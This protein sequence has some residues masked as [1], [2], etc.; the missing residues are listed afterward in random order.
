M[1]KSILVLIALYLCVFSIKAQ[2]SPDERD[3]LKQLN[4][5]VVT[6]YKAGKIDDALI[7]AKQSVD[8]SVKVFGAE[9]D[10][11]AAA[12]SNLGTLYRLKK[13]YTEAAENLQKAL[14]IYNLRP[15]KNGKSLAKTLDNLAAVYALDGDRK[16]AAETYQTALIAAENAFGKES[17]ELLPYLKSMTDV[18]VFNKKL[19]EAQEVLARRYKIAEKSLPDDTTQLTE[20]S[21][22]FTCFVH[23]NFSREEV[24]GRQKQFSEAT[25]SEEDKIS[26]SNNSDKNIKG[27]VVNSKA[28]NLVAPVYP[29]NARSR[30]ASGI[31]VVKVTIDEEGKVI[32]AAPA[33]SGDIDLLSASVAAAKKSKFTPTL[34]GGQP[35]K[36]TGV[37]V[38]AFVP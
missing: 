15:A 25:K 32:S 38:Y 16:K 19:D 7:L 6:T 33:C 24:P 20:I 14:A 11:T 17:A 13:K 9:H 36:V 31:I 21:D 30:F 18:Y 10:E 29:P 1:K 26:D 12:Y 34:L 8:L 35:V 23:Q 28:K 4:Q 2:T 22:E 5:Q 3:K 27:G 37:I